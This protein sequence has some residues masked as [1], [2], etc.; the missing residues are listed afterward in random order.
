VKKI[1]NLEP[2]DYYTQRN[3]TLYPST[4]C[5]PTARAMFY[6]GNNIKFKN[7]SELSDD[8]YFMSLLRSEEAYVFARKKYPSLMDS[9]YQPNELHG[10][11]SSF[12]DLKVV[13]KRVSDFLTDITFKNVVERMF[14]G[15]VLMTSGKFPD[16]GLNGHAFCIIGL[17][18]GALGPALIL[19]D[20]WGDFRKDFR[21]RRGYSVMMTEEEF[22]IHVKPL[23]E[24]KWAHIPIK[25]KGNN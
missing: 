9:G 6:H 1:I 10:M 17:V 18:N 22:K 5:M 7:P 16:A 11:Y 4:A 25:E 13:G 14:D 15:E 3:N 24:L 20:P 21:S 12:L 19:A 2:K 8:D 23:Q